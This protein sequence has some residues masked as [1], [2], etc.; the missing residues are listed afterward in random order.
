[1]TL[2][3]GATEQA[4][5]IEELNATIHTINENTRQNAENAEKAEALSD[6]LKRYAQEGNEDMAN[7]VNSM[8]GIKDSSDKISKII[9]VID[10]IA[11]QTN[12]LA[13][14]AA[15]E[16]A[17]AGEH[18]KGFAVVAEEVRNLAGKT[19]VSAKETAALIED[20][21][22]RV[23]DGTEIANKTAEMLNHILSEAG[24]VAGVITEITRSS[25]EQSH[26]IEQVMTGLSQVTEVVQNNSATAEE[27]AA[28]AEE[29]SS[30]SELLRESTRVFKLK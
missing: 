30:Q 19:S 6:K 23:N 27:S 8:N 4:S 2:A 18:G 5:S 3:T 13:L 14:N 1:M 29:L 21:I 15:V 28:A 10:D 24:Q 7:M 16:A 22:N 11:F 9:K 26:S 17:R 25:G 12:L 20:D